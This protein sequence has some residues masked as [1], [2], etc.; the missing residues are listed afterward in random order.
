MND[1]T[2]IGATF[3]YVKIIVFYVKNYNND[4]I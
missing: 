4:I 1:F 2:K 3:F